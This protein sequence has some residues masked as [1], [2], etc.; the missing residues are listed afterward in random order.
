[1][2]LG[3]IGFPFRQIPFEP[4]YE[5]HAALLVAVV[6]ELGQSIQTSWQGQCGTKRFLNSEIA[7]ALL[8]NQSSSHRRISCDQI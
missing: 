1:M 4:S 6:C 3:F 5:I 7:S 8:L 2:Q